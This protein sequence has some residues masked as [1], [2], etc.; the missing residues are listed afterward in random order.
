MDPSGSPDTSS[1]L[2]ILLHECVERVL[3]SWRR[4]HPDAIP[5]DRAVRRFL[6]ALG[7]LEQA[8]DALSGDGEVVLVH[9]GTVGRGLRRRKVPIS[10]ADEL[11]AFGVP[12]LADVYSELGSE[13]EFSIDVKD[14]AG[15]EEECRLARSLGFRG[16]A[17]IHPQQVPIVNHV[18]APSRA[19]VEWARKVIEVYDQGVGDGRGV[20]ALNGAMVDL[21]VVE[22]ARRILAEAER[23]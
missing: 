1:P 8:T 7:S 19:E 13:F 6:D 18:F 9:D 14:D 20:V 3:S 17:C 12:R 22:R 21:P 16:K 11:A 15:L 4:L 23:S 10:T 2:T 5:P